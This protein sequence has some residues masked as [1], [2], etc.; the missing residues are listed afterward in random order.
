MSGLLTSRGHINI[1]WRHHK[2]R[3]HFIKNCMD[4]E[5][6]DE[7]AGAVWFGYGY[8]NYYMAYCVVRGHKLYC[9][10]LC[11]CIAGKLPYGSMTV[12]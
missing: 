9:K 5:I 11:V 3:F 10:D 1:Y 4:V 8:D 2:Y 6:A 7:E 12:Q